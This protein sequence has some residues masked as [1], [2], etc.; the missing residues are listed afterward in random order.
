MRLRLLSLH[1]RLQSYVTTRRTV[2]YVFL[3]RNVSNSEYI[4]AVRVRAYRGV[5][6]LWV[7]LS[8]VSLVC[9]AIMSTAKCVKLATVLLNATTCLS[10]SKVILRSEVGKPVARPPP[11]R[12]AFWSDVMK[13]YIVNRLTSFFVIPFT[14]FWQANNCQLSKAAAVL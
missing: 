13:D 10:V 1:G 5:G 2:R 7:Y 11:P 3:F 8:V 6:Y 14:I 4:F 12:G 9:I